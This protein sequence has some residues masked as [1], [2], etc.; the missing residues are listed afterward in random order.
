[1][2]PK[3]QGGVPG[4]SCPWQSEDC[5]QFRFGISL[6]TSCRLATAT[7]GLSGAKN[8]GQGPA[9]QAVPS[10]PVPV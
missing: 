3:A 8:P 4:S 2:V 7:A 6:A 9:V 5:M 10:L 1:M